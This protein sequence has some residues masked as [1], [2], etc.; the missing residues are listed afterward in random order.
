MLT[1]ILYASSLLGALYFVI[2]TL[3]KKHEEMQVF[4]CALLLLLGLQE[5]V[6]SLLFLIGIG[7]NQILSTGINVLISVVLFLRLPKEAAKNRDNDKSSSPNIT[8]IL[9]SLIAQADY[10]IL[11]IILIVVMGVI[12]YIRFGIPMVPSFNSSDSGFHFM[13]S[14][15]VSEG[16]IV[17][18]QFASWFVNGI[19]MSIFTPFISHEHLLDVY[20]LSESGILVLSGL[21]LYSTLGVLCTLRPWQKIIITLL[22][23]LGLPLKSFL[24][25]YSYLHFACLVMNALIYYMVSYRAQLNHV[26]SLVPLSIFCFM[27]MISYSL[28]VP[29][30]FMGVFLALTFVLRKDFN[31]H[32][33]G[34]F[35]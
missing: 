34:G 31:L 25:G 29:G 27:L 30:V 33:G 21:L 23:V 2:Q 24:F 17:E 10:I 22:Y 5:L 3:S 18:T 6:F 4:P 8:G 12:I 16:T 28:F 11:A 9:N 20:I 26:V 35:L 14:R 19:V 7:F 15:L 32:G 13:Q 1:S